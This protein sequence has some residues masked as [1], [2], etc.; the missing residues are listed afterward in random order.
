MIDNEDV[1]YRLPDSAIFKS[2]IYIHSHAYTFYNQ[3]SLRTASQNAAVSQVKELQTGVTQILRDNIKKLQEVH[4]A[5]SNAGID[6]SLM[7]LHNSFLELKELKPETLTQ[8]TISGVVS[9]YRRK[10]EEKII[11]KITQ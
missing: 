1:V 3:I 6:L 2:P 10:L 11:S 7:D 4:D 5:Y 8:N 9:S